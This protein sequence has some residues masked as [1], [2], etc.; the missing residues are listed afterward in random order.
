MI[1]DDRRAVDAPYPP[2]AEYGLIGDCHAVALISRRGSIDWCCLPRLD[3]AS[4]FGRLLDW[5]AGGHCAIT[6]DDDRVAA[7]RSYA[8]GSLVLETR[9]R[10][11]DGEV[12][13]VDFFAMREGGR[14]RPRRQLVRIVEGVAGALALAVAVAPRFDH[15]A[16][17][18]WLR[19]H[20]PG[21]W[22]A[23]GGDTALVLR[24]DMPLERHGEHDL[25]ATFPVRAGQ[26]LRLAITHAEPHVVHPGPPVG[27]D[28]EALD[29]R[30][31]ETRAWWAAW[32][33]RATPPAP[34]AAE[35][36][37]SA[38]VIK[39]LVH[40]PTGAI[41]AAPTTSLPE[42]VGGA[43]NWDYRYT[44]IRDSTFA[45]R[46]LQEIG[47]VAEARGFARFIERTTAGDAAGLQVL[48]G[49]R[50]A[51]RLPELELGALPGYR[52]SRP[53]RIGNQA[54]CQLQLDVHGHLLDL[55]WR[56]STSGRRT[57]DRYWSFLAAI[58]ERVAVQWR[59]PDRGPW[60]VRGEPRHF[61][62]SKVMCWAALD[63]ALRLAAHE[64]REAPTRRW[65]AAR[66]E[67][68]RTIEA[69]GLDR[70]RGAYVQAFGGRELDA[71]LLLVP[72]V[73]FVA[74]DDPAML[75]TVDAIRDE[76]DP[77]DGLLRRY[78]GDDG[79]PD[80]EGAF[81]ACTFWLAECLARQGRLDDAR[82]A[83]ARARATA[84]DLGL[85][86]EEYDPARR[87]LLGNFPQGL[88][89]YSHIAAAVALARA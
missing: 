6:P 82:A 17:K 63:R 15:G 81:V 7:E 38:A 54:A 51:H 49:V 84:N 45:L 57:D 22:T 89:H 16:I 66:D 39:A 2:L 76:L 69:D 40:A 72:R 1:R 25:R 9:F 70:G 59:L 4:C 34:H 60:E 42:R 79:L 14:D 10:G 8:D 29:H 53:V 30:L 13:L 21:L 68:R 46:S 56:T 35:V 36:L 55:A 31:A 32:L 24:T 33:L 37:R 5:E 27:A 28:I 78:R 85:F 41:A 75:R 26:R 44:W 23:I 50:G 74:W 86:A 83:F 19:A 52:G 71:A 47:Y 88:S 73:D 67:V 80:L 58:V 12:L 43:R 48:Y 61:V 64:R 20:G 87:E 11:D 77:G 18:P 62:Y 3:S 65:V